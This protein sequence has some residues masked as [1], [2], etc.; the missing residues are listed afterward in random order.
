[1]KMAANLMVFQKYFDQWDYSLKVVGEKCLK[2]IQN[3]WNAEKV[4]LMIGEEPSPLFFSRIFSKF[5]TVVEESDLTPTQQNLQ[6]QQMMEINERFGREVFPPSMIIPKLNI[7]GKG[8]IIPFL[9]QQEQQAQAVQSEAQNIQHTFEEMKMKELMAKIH[10]QLSM[11]RERDAR[12]ESNVGLFEERMSEISKNHALAT[13]EKMEALT[14]LLEA[15]QKFGELET[16][17]QANNLESIKLDEEETE[18]N[19]RMSIEQNE[20]AKKFYQQIMALQPS[21]PQQ[22]QQQG[23]MSQAA[24]GQ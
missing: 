2:I 16:F 6:A 13:K 5:H 4:G 15:V 9:Q 21:I 11:S 8:E 20:S 10:N 17:L 23:Q 19:A 7:T 14:K 24:V 3:N 22:N 12:S 18:K 1:M